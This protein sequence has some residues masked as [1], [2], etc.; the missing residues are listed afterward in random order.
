MAKAIRK[1]AEEKGFNVRTLDVDAPLKAMNTLR[2][3]AQKALNDFNGYSANCLA[4]DKFCQRLIDLAAVMDGKIV[5][6]D[7]IEE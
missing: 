1:Y 5:L 4:N 3:F 6:A 2:L 7:T